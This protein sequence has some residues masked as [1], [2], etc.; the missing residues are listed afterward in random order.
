MARLLIII[1]AIAIIGS[2]V[3]SRYA[4]ETSLPPTD[5]YQMIG[6]I[7]ITNTSIIAP[8]API[9]ISFF[10]FLSRKR[11]TTVIRINVMLNPLPKAFSI[12]LASGE[13][14]EGIREIKNIILT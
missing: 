6:N 11:R 5:K 9:R 10:L 3:F 8:M 2:M 7:P 4:G 12:R 13:K 14:L 1:N